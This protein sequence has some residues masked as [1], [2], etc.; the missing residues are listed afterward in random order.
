MAKSCIYTYFNGMLF[1]KKQ[2]FKFTFAFIAMIIIF[3]I[4]MQK[5]SFIIPFV[6]VILYYLYYSFP[7]GF[8]NNMHM[9]LL[10]AL[11]FLPFIAINLS[12]FSDAAFAIAAIFVMRT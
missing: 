6:I 1:K 3:M 4:D 5:I 7:R 8:I 12:E 9:F 2:F 11:L 10:L